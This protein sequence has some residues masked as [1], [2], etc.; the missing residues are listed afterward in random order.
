V[1]SEKNDTSPRLM[2]L[3]GNLI[4]VT[5]GLV[6]SEKKSHKSTLNGNVHED[7]NKQCG[8]LC[9]TNKQNHKSTPD[10]NVWKNQSL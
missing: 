10:V 8:D 6:L 9:S 7:D 4:A 5:V 3:C 2:L 1:L